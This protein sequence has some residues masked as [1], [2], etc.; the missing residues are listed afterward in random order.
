MADLRRAWHIDNL[1]LAWR[2]VRSNPDRTYKSYF[3]E[4]YTAYAI[5]DEALLAHLQNRLSRD[6]YQASDACKI[7]FPKPSGILRPYSLLAIED[8]I[9][10]Q[11]MA[12]V[13]AEELFPHV[14][15]RYNKEV[16][17]HLYAGSSSTWFYRKW[18]EGY[19]AFNTGAENAF[20][21]GYVWTA[22]FDLTAFYDSIDHNVLRRML[23]DIGIDRD[24]GLALTEFLTKWTATSTRIYHNHGIPQGPLSSGLIAETVLKHFDD[25]HNTRHDVRYFRYV[26]DIRL[27]AKKEVHL[28][29]ALVV[30]D[31]LSK[32]VGLFPQS[33]KIDIHEVESIEKELKSISNPVEPVL[34]GLALDQRALRNRIAEMTPR[35]KHYK[36]ES[37][38]RFKYLVAKAAPSPRLADRLWRIY[39]RAPH[40]YPQLAGHL[41]KFNPIPEK[42]ARLLIDEIDAQELYPAIRASLILASVGRLPASA[43]KRGRS[44]L[45]SIWK[46]RQNQPD[47]A[48]ALWRWLHR[49]NHLTE[50]Q[51]Q[52]GLLFSN[53]P[54]LRMRLHYGTP[55]L[56]MSPLHRERWLNKSLRSDSA[57]VAISAAWLCGLLDVKIQKPFQAINAQARLALKEQGLIRRAN[58]SVCGIQ[59]AIAE[60]TGHNIPI[61]WRK[62]F[63]RAYKRAEAQA[64]TCKAYFKTNASAWTNS[65]DVFVDLLLDALYRK[66]KSLG[67]YQLGNVG[68]V[69]KST[70]LKA[71]YPA[72]FEL[73]NQIH[74]KRSESNLSHAITK[75][76]KRSTK[77]IK[78]KWLTTGARLLRKAANEL[79]TKGY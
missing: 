70:A 48:D 5:A 60:T 3:R 44:K 75:T 67:L 29:H 31:R 27:F 41:S 63:G 49:E 58:A 38:T 42:H 9:V 19:K 57:D 72:V 30:L 22:S 8:Q 36:V 59:H 50:A 52:H 12:N 11:A 69:A 68:G 20:K 56:E 79:E 14:W 24:F 62:L 32:D 17:G 37:P 53:P 26:D 6:V 33:G 65:M 1:R 45:K 77:P 15:H 74:T 43:V 13:V 78:F 39:W 55:W 16:F 28:R 21:S 73:L 10:Y 34:T 71:G 18:S 64:I 7:F 66:D 47:L 4:L 35:Q 23:E 2:R 61:Q 51:I 40:Y 46:P 25:R 76:T 54:W